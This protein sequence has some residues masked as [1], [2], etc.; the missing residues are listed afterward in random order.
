MATAASIKVSK[1]F[2]FKGSLRTWSNR[3]HF[4]NNAPT[5]TTKWT[6]LSDAIVTAEKACLLASG[7][8]VT[9]VATHGYDAGSEVPVFSK[10]YATVGTYPPAGQPIAPGDA[11]LL[12]RYST[13]ARTS[14]NHPLYLFN[15]YH[16][17]CLSSSTNGDVPIGSQKSAFSTYATSW[18]TGFTD[19]TVVHSRCGPNGHVATGQL[20]STYISHRDFPPA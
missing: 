8:T 16:G 1:T 5:D 20:V 9:I 14:K 13:I 19:G 15:W 4:T 2:T 7:N 3:Y 10:T 6:T 17:I 11:A 18:V 12:T